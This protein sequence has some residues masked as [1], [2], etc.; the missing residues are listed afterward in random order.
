MVMTLVSGMT[1]GRGRRVAMP[2]VFMV[3]VLTVMRVV[4]VLFHE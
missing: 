3:A 1:P 4:N 2:L